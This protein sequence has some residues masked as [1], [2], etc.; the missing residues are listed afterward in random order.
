MNEEANVP[1][2]VEDSMRPPQPL[3]RQI[4]ISNEPSIEEHT[5]SS[6]DNNASFTA[7]I[8]EEAVKDE[9]FNAAD[10][11]PNISKIESIEPVTT[12]VLQQDPKSFNSTDSTE[13]FLVDI[14]N[15]VLSK[16]N[17]TE[18]SQTTDTITEN[19][20]KVDQNSN[21]N[22][23]TTRLSDE[24]TSSISN[25]ADTNKEKP[26]ENINKEFS[27]SPNEI[28][29]HFMDVASEPALLSQNTS[30]TSA[31]D[32]S[33]ITTKNISESKQGS[34]SGSEES[35]SLTSDN[36]TLDGTNT[37]AMTISTI[38]ED[39]S[40]D[41]ETTTDIN[42]KSPTRSLENLP[43]LAEFLACKI[44]ATAMFPDSIE[45]IESL[46]MIDIISLVPTPAEENKDSSESTFV[47]SKSNEDYI[48]SSTLMVV[49][50]DKI[51]ATQ[52]DLTTSNDN[53]MQSTT[54]DE[55]IPSS[56]SK[57]NTTTSAELI[58]SNSTD[59]NND[60]KYLSSITVHDNSNGK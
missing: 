39:E 50:N 29:D 30:I 28:H 53:H 46:E 21:A 60:E 59:I 25:T 20:T 45:Y 6:V 26:E 18:T 54:I 37:E 2:L 32:T 9:N 24:L 41:S 10:S 40:S 7:Q 27:D 5:N 15:E 57:M 55:V 11:A 51:D 38:K 33:N 17:P 31:S 42:N 49:D 47:T 19:Q 1:A 8:N 3:L 22:D 4:A 34:I 36:T 14:S 43:A 44:L 13:I 23:S 12:D 56:K 52:D 16:Y 48:T 58:K 35:Y